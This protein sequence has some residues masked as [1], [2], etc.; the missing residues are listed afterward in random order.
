MD[1]QT[2]FM[3][4][5]FVAIES[6]GFGRRIALVGAERPHLPVAL[7]LFVQGTP[8]EVADTV[9]WLASPD[10]DYVNGA[11]LNIDGGWLAR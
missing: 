11:I 5:I 6:S 1:G 9:L 8:A 3:P 2:T 10:A 7:S 4:W